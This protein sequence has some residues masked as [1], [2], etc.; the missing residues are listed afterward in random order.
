MG[1]TMSAVVGPEHLTVRKSERWPKE[2]VLLLRRT[3]SATD[4]RVTFEIVSAKANGLVTTRARGIVVVDPESALPDP[5]HPDGRCYSHG[6]V[7]GKLS[8]E[9]RSR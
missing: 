8:K 9:L 2:L 4:A 6:A 5:A 1:D 7:F 3:V